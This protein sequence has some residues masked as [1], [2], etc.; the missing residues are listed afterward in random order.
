[1]NYVCFRRMYIRRGPTAGFSSDPFGVTLLLK[2][3]LLTL[4]PVAFRGGLEYAPKLLTALPPL[5]LSPGVTL[6]L[7]CSPSK[8]T[9]SYSP[10]DDATLPLRRRYSLFPIYSLKY[11]SKSTH[12]PPTRTITR[13]LRT[14][15]YKFCPCT[16]IFLASS[17]TLECE[18]A[19]E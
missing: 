8:S 2:S 19:R 10:T 9:N 12:P 6:L 16:S 7:P 4:P 1:V 11:C 18:E 15:T 17:A 5:P 14:R 13:S 3:K